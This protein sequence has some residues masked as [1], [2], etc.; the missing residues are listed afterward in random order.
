M[1]KLSF[2]GVTFASAAALLPHTATG[3]TL[4]GVTPIQSQIQAEAAARAAADS[5]LQSA[6]AAEAAARAGMDATLLDA[7][8]EVRAGGAESSIVGT[9][10]FSGTLTCLTSTFGFNDDL[11]PVA[12]PGPTRTAVVSAFTSVSTGFRTFNSDGT[13]TAQFFSQVISMP[14][15]FFTTFPSSGVTM[16]GPGGKPSGGASEAEQTSTFT[17]HIEGNKLFIEEDSVGAVG[18]IKRGGSTQGCTIRNVN[19]PRAVGVLGKDLRIIS[20]SH[21]AVKVETGITECPDGRVFTSQRICNRE[22]TLRKM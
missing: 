15:A 6:I 14:G 16:G 12:S 17:W 18:V 5:Q 20:I 21:E 1:K 13:G 22:R 11:T 9:Y 2:W 4:P 7:I 10:T 3:Q 19:T 8:D